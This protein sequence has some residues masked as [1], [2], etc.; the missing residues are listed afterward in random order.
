MCCLTMGIRSEKCA[1]RWFHFCVNV[2]EC[3][4]TNFEN[5]HW[6]GHLTDK[7]PFRGPFPERR[8]HPYWRFGLAGNFPPHS[9]Y[10]DFLKILTTIIYAVRHWPKCH[11]AAH[12]RN[13][14]FFG[15]V[16]YLPLYC[17]EL[18]RIKWTGHV[19][20]D[21]QHQSLEC[22]IANFRTHVSTCAPTPGILRVCTSTRRYQYICFMFSRWHGC[23]LGY[24]KCKAC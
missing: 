22:W 2:L 16:H 18:T 17:I 14:L 1:V 7:S 12:D 15:F 13:V 3:T 8:F 6:L 5:W 21:L 20:T 11:Y 9:V 19:I 24:P 10:L 4:Y 23:R